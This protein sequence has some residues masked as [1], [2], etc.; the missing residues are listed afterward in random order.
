M[1]DSGPPPE[2]LAVAGAAA[3]EVESPLGK[4]LLAATSQGLTRIAFEE[5]HDAAALSAHAASRRGSKTARQHLTDARESL[6]RYFA[7]DLNVRGCAIDW[8]Q[9]TPAG[10]SLQATQAIPY[11]TH[12]SYNDLGLQLAPHEL[13]LILGSN[14]IP[15]VTPCHRV[16]RGTEIPTTYVG[17]PDRR[18]WLDTHELT[19]S[20]T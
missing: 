10:A 11:A 2:T 14:P 9:L 15:I 19:H 13:G 20:S 7:G 17:G 6:L 3:T 4:L 16:S 18:R 5:H 1:L 8:Q 12:C